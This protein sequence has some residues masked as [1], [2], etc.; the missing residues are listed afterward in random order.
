MCS[1]T[2]GTWKWQ[3]KWEQVLLV[4]LRSY[5]YR[6]QWCSRVRFTSTMSCNWWGSLTRPLN[7]MGFLST[8]SADRDYLRDLWFLI[9]QISE[10][11]HKS[12]DWQLLKELW[13]FDRIVCN[14]V[15]E[16]VV[17]GRQ[18]VQLYYNNDWEQQLI[19]NLWVS[20][21][22][23]N[24][25]NTDYYWRKDTKAKWKYFW[26]KYIQGLREFWW[27]YVPLIHIRKWRI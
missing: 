26:I 4:C 1:E 17:R 3:G 24:V 5:L 19:V 7:C 9:Y 27:I 22:N 2:K 18:F 16:P 12:V 8:D 11:R 6:E 21:F 25:S 13:N 20:G 10:L 14:S 15:T 23:F